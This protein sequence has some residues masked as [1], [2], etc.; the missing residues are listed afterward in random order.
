[1]HPSLLLTGNKVVLWF[2][3]TVRSFE[4]EQKAKLLQFVTG[5][6]G[7][8]IQGFAYLQGNDGNVRKF[9]RHGD[10]NVKVV[11][12]AHTCFNRY[13]ACK[14]SVYFKFCSVESS[15]GARLCLL[16]IRPQI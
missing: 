12:R 16:V 6:S 15:A 7:V 3:E 5:T 2:W 9:T 1:L 10:R 4:Q 11:P 14:L 13:G 8:P